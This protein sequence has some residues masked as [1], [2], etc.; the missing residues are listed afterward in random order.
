MK[1]PNIIL[2]LL[3][4]L[5]GCAFVVAGGAGRPDYF[6]AD[7]IKATLIKVAQWQLQHQTGRDMRGAANGVFYSGIFAAHQA[8]GNQELLTAV[9]RWAWLAES[10]KFARKTN[11]ENT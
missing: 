6:A 1:L 10:A 11:Y 7:Y 3:S 4:F 5:S 9:N 8:T 2:I